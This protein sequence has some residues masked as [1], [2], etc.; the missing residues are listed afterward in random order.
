MQDEAR[1]EVRNSEAVVAATQRSHA[2]RTAEVYADLLKDTIMIRT[3]RTRDKRHTSLA[4][5]AG[6][7]EAK[8]VRFTDFMGHCAH[9]GGDQYMG[10]MSLP[11][12]TIMTRWRRGGAC[13]V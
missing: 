9:R 12:R 6:L 11:R 1:L 8:A 5:G 10:G 3:R 4:Q 7:I 13:R 2:H